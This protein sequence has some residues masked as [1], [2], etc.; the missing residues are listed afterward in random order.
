MFPINCT[1]FLSVLITKIFKGL[2]NDLLTVSGSVFLFLVPAM[3]RRAALFS[4]MLFWMDS[5]ILCF[6]LLP[7]ELYSCYLFL[8][9]ARPQDL[10]LVKD[11]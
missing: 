5:M 11:L 2:K 7:I 6:D 3:G 8:V 1:W 9:L 10:E 4:D